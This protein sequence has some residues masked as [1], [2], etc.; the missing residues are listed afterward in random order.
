VFTIDNLL[1]MPDDDGL[2]YELFEGT[3]IVSPA[4]GGVHQIAIGR[5]VWLLSAF[6]T[7]GYQVVPDAS[8]D[9]GDNTCLEPDVV[10]LRDPL[11]AVDSAFPAH[12]VLGAME[13]VSP[14]SRS[15]D[16]TIKPAKYAAAG[17][18]TYWRIETSRFRRQFDDD[19][20]V[21]FVY[22]LSSGTYVERARLA[23][24]DVGKVELPYPVAFDPT[25]LMGSPRAMAETVRQLG[26]ADPV[27]VTGRR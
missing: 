1:D 20:P 12:D 25:A 7:E 21:V 5:L 2:Q 24:G 4:P 8:V 16:R 19:L 22:E 14:S 23:A 10:V 6:A 3:L 13:V 15:L 18:G 26:S 17:I 9:L 27:S 11:D